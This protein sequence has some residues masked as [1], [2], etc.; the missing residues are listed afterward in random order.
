VAL[1][2]LLPVA[3]APLLRFDRDMP[4]PELR[5]LGH[6]AAAYLKPGDRVALMLPKDYEDSIGSFMRGV[7]LFT[8]PRR[9]GLDF[10]IE[11]DVTPA[12]LAAATA[13]ADRLALVT[14]APPGLDGVPPGDAA[15]L[16]ATP[17]GWQVVQTWAWPS[18]IKQQEFSAML[19]RD[20]LCAGPRPR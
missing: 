13:D 10:R 11:T 4:Q 12:T 18:R 9:P 19:A 6:A 7:L 1:A 2:L 16:Q 8:P 20:P 15:V 5:Q 17:G 3:G 14:C